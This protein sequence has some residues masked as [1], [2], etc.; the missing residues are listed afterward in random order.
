MIDVA[1]GRASIDAETTRSLDVLRGID[2]WRSPTRLPDWSVGDL[3]RHLVWG[4]RLQADAWRRVGAGDT[5]TA[6]ASE[7]LATDRSEVLEALIAANGELGA[8]LE[9]VT[10][11]Q[12]ESALCAMPYG[13]MPAPF[14]LLLATMEAGVHR[15]D[16]AAAAGLDDA[17]DEKTVDAATTVL[18]GTL[19]L[20]GA[21]GDGTAP[22][23][24]SVLLRAP[25]F[26][27]AALRGDDGWTVGAP[28]ERPSTTI[29]GSASDIVL[30]ALGRRDASSLDVGGDPAGADRFKAWFPGP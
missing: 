11:E 26:E 22:L 3:A 25:G 23:G 21:A 5:G 30:F 20:L 7:L 12:A 6:T 8:A 15:S 14:V 17:L 9:K 18:G 27:L 24:T 29:A 2:D 4:Q 19:P 16:L 1:T 13:T 28:P 10:D